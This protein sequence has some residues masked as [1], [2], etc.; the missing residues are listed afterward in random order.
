MISGSSSSARSR[1]SA[2][3]PSR[4]SSCSRRRGLAITSETGAPSSN[5][6]EARQPGRTSDEKDPV[7]GLSSEG[8]S[9]LRRR[10]AARKQLQGLHRVG[11]GGSRSRRIGEQADVVAQGRQAAREPVGD[12]PRLAADAVGSEA[13]AEDGDPQG[14]ARDGLRLDHA[15]CSRRSP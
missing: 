9:E 13:R 11:C 3:G 4:S 7:D 10:A 2:I 1:H 8:G 12:V 6:A 5:A 15:A 14:R